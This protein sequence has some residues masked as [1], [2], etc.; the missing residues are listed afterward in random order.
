MPIEGGCHC[1]AIRYVIDG[2]PMTGVICHCSDCRKAAGAPMVA[3]SMYP[4]AAVT[5][6]AGAPK[7]YSSSADGRRHFCA[8]CGTGVFYLNAAE[9]PGIIDVQTATFDDPAILAPQMHI[10]TAERIGWA[11]TLHELPEHGRFPPRR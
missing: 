9:L 1:G 5:V 3:W 7:V 8:E 4:E 2:T 11:A 10:Q 6:T